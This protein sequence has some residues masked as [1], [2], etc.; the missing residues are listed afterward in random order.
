[1]S[2][3]KRTYFNPDDWEEKEEQD[4]FPVIE[5]TRA[6]VTRTGVLTGAPLI[7]IRSR[8]VAVRS[9][10]IAVLQ[11]GDKVIILDNAENHFYKIQ[12]ENDNVGYVSCSFCE[13]VKHG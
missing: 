7:R 2:R 9:E 8:P 3:K 11:R 5:E 4:E 13:E 6:P 10:V 1:M 12:L